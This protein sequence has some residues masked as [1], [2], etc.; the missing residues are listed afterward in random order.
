MVEKTYAKEELLGSTHVG[1][2]ELY[3]GNKRTISAAIKAQ[4]DAGIDELEKRL[5][6]PAYQELVKRQGGIKPGN[7]MNLRIK[8]EIV[9]E[10]D[11]GVELQKIR[12]E[13]ASKTAPAAPQTT[14]PE[15]KPNTGDQANA[16]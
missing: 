4:V 15:L 13:E 12:A 14:A 10:T 2:A 7:E 11:F 8:V 3:L 5:K 16:A 6:D 1:A 9:Q